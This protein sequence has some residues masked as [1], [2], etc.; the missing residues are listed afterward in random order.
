MPVNYHFA[1]SGP[2]RPFTHETEAN[3][4]SLPPANATRTPPPR[5]D[6]HWPV[7]NGSG[8]ELAE[9]HRG[10]KGYIGRAPHEIAGLGPLPEGFAAEPPPPSDEELREAARAALLAE[11]NELDFKTVRPLRAIVAAMEDGGGGV[12]QADVERLA[13]LEAEARAKRAEL[14]ELAEPPAGEPI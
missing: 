6:G 7:W 4:G 8:W 13:A 1:P 10:E 11:I 9:D 2:L 3:P 14:A 12:D 5:E